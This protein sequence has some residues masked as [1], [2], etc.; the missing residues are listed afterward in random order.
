MKRKYDSDDD[1]NPDNYFYESTKDR[2]T[3]EKDKK[4]LKEIEKKIEERDIG[5]IDIMKIDHLT[6]DEYIWFVEHIQILRNTDKYT[7]DYYRIKNKIYNRYKNLDKNFKLKKLSD[8]EADTDIVTQ[9]YNSNHSDYIK[10][11]LYKKYL[12][13]DDLDK[14]EEYFKI[15]DWINIVLD[16]PTKIKTPN[17]KK[18]SVNNKLI[19]LKKCLDKKIYGLN[20]VKE[21]IIEA[22]CS[23][24]T[25]PNYKKDIITLVGPPGTGKT[26]LGEA[27]ANALNQPFS[28]IS[29]GSIKDPHSLTGFPSTYVG[30]QPGQ[31]VNILKNTKKLNSVILLDEVD[32]I[33]ESTEGYSISSV[34]L[35]VLDKTQNNNFRDMY[36]PEIPIDL[37]NIFFILSMNNDKLVNK[38]LRDRLYIIKIDGYTLNEKIIIGKK[39]ILPRILSEL[40]FKEDDLEIDDIIMRYI[41]EKNITDK[42]VRSLERDITTI[43]EKINVLKYTSL[44]KKRIKLSYHIEELNFPLKITKDIV[45]ILLN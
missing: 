26:A 8:N 27:I 41:I 29:F 25:N 6:D 20:N 10:S 42:G 43:C 4:K 18:S 12:L 35:H 5:L 24:L 30:S 37:S 15:V 39:Y 13:L 23:M 1:Y 34:L 40:K 3:N 32:K 31:F 16:L 2:L 44:G 14:S 45:D 21:K 17:I 7:E 36:M 9:I 38:I 28:Q 33:P 19:K 22:Y 11:I